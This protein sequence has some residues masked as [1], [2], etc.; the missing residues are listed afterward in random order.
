LT[1]SVLFTV[2]LRIAVRI[3][4]WVSPPRGSTCLN[5]RPNVSWKM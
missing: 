5:V 1:V 3:S 4:S 2:A